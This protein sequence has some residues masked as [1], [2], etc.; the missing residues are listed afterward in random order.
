V[1]PALNRYKSEPAL[2]SWEFAIQ[3]ITVPSVEGEGVD[4]ANSVVI[5][6][7]DGD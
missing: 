2:T 6:A 4:G 5:L 7:N 3:L 1:R